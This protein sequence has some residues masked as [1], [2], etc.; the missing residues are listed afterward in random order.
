MLILSH[1]DAIFSKAFLS[2]LSVLDIVLLL[3]LEI[4]EKIKLDILTYY[5]NARPIKIL[6]EE[7]VVYYIIKAKIWNISELF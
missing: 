7:S 1:M 5:T 6:F 3:C 2:T 4:P